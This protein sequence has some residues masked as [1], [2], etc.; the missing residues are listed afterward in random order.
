M[1]GF[2]YTQNHEAIIVCQVSQGQKH[3]LFIS[4]HL[5]KWEITINDGFQK[6][7]LIAKNVIFL[8][9]NQQNVRSILER[10]AL[11]RYVKN[12]IANY[13]IK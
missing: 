12:D 7:L 11:L 9:I 10:N 5:Y 13:R 6:L 1:D 2:L 4:H 3:H 8:I